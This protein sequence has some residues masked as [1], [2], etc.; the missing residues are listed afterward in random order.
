MPSLVPS[1]FKTLVNAQAAQ[2]L[3]KLVV[4]GAQQVVA[5]T[6]V[7]GELLSWSPGQLIEVAITGNGKLERLRRKKVAAQLAIEFRL[8]IGPAPEKAEATLYAFQV[9]YFTE[10]QLRGFMAQA[11]AANEPATAYV[12]FL[13]LVRHERHVRKTRDRAP[14]KSPPPP[15]E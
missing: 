2:A 4:V 1:F 3:G 12:R 15:T 7:A 8:Q 10:A 11:A 13:A 14:P 9:Q 5:L 6:T